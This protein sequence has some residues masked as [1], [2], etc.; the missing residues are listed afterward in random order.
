MEREIDREEECPAGEYRGDRE[1]RQSRRQRREKERAGERAAR[2][3]RAQWTAA[4]IR[5][6]RDSGF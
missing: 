6:R 2:E 4:E 5:K 1:K 3:G